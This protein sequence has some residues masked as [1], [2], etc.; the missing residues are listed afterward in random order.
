MADE[1]KQMCKTAH[2]YRAL[3]DHAIHAQLHNKENIMS[4]EL[5]K[6]KEDH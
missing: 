4:K 5:D 3:P 6:M 2:K 1:L